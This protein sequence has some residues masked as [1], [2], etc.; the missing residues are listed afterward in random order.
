MAINLDLGVD[1]TVTNESER[2]PWKQ[3]KLSYNDQA[4][5]QVCAKGGGVVCVCVWVCRC[6]RAC[7]HTH[8]WLRLTK[9]APVAVSKS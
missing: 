3:N 7:T 4:R 6:V 5:I 1:W 2:N 8:I 9:W